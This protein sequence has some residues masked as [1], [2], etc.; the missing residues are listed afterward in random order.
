MVFAAAR[1]T[2]HRCART[3]AA[4]QQSCDEDDDFGFTFQSAW[5]AFGGLSRFA[6]FAGLRINNLP[7]LGADA[8]ADLIDINITLP[9][10]TRLEIDRCEFDDN[11]LLQVGDISLPAVRHFVVENCVLTDEFMNTSTKVRR[12][13]LRIC[14][15]SALLVRTFG[16]VSCQLPLSY[17]MS[18]QLQLLCGTCIYA[19]ALTPT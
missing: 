4:T 16:Y 14:A 10:L 6:S 18:L 15:L 3:H 8:L 11:E 1:R 12:S 9:A 5:A 17:T 7:N 2:S 13:K 19:L